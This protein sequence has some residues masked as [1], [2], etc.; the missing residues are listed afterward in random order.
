MR[1]SFA[2]NNL[3]YSHR[4]KIAEDPFTLVSECAI[5]V[6]YI[7]VVWLYIKYFLVVHKVLFGCT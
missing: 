1:V 2:L 3:F 5:W 6:L 7:S 4:V